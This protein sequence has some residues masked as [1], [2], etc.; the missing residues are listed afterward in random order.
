MIISHLLWGRQ[1]FKRPL[2]FCCILGAHHMQNIR[3]V[4]TGRCDR[5]KL[6]DPHQGRC[7]VQ[8]CAEQ[9]AG[10]P[11]SGESSQIQRCCIW[12]I[13][14]TNGACVQRPCSMAKNGNHTPP[15]FS[16]HTIHSVSC[17]LHRTLL[18]LPGTQVLRR[19]FGFWWQWIVQLITNTKRWCWIHQE[20]F[21]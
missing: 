9:P 20:Y 14:W 5:T 21:Y 13:Q 16:V 11:A 12:N 19:P 10:L 15:A 17:E 6:V 1:V 2:P 8:Q 7:L 18:P 3:T 4:Y